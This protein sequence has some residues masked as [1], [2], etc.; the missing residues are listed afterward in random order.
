MFSPYCSGNGDTVY[1][2]LS[3]DW[4]NAETVFMLFFIVLWQG[5]LYGCSLKYEKN[6]MCRMSLI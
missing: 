6:G 2:L 4:G 5:C 3:A 1:R